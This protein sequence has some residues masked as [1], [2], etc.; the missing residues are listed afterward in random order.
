LT[1]YVAAHDSTSRDNMFKI[2]KNVE[3]AKV[4]KPSGRRKKYP[5][6]DLDVGDMF[7][8]P[9]KTTNTMMSQ[10]S[11]AGKQLGRKFSTRL[12]WMANVE[13]DWIPCTE[14]AKDKVMG[15]AVWRVE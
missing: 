15:V 2:Q 3:V 14:S 9:N 6:A 11:H 10:A 12:I 1:I 13:G 7:F 4:R 8:I 5:F